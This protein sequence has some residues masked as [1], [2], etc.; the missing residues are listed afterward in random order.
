MLESAALAGLRGDSTA[1]DLRVD[2]L[3]YRGGT[4]LL[5]T[6]VTYGGVGAF[7][8]ALM[9]VVLFLMQYRSL[10]VEQAAA[11]AAISAISAADFPEI[12][13]AMSSGTTAVTTMAQLT[14]DA[15]QRAEMLGSGANVTPPTIDLV[16]QIT[17][18]FPPHPTVTV[19]VRSMS[20]GPENISF[21]AET[22]GYA[23]SAKVEET[24]QTSELFK[25]ATKGDETRLSNGRVRFPIS[26]PL[27]GEASADD[28]QEG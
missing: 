7:A 12:P 16:A 3:V 13:S 26:I 21:E 23:S 5:R 19:E 28:G 27:G 20:I 1:V 15:Q 10:S 11:E 24:L 9:S 17:E 22:D 14:A 18:A 6:V 8:F 2:D 4:D 25:G